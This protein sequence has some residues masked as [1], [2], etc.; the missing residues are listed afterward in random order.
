[1][2]EKTKLFF[3]LTLV[4][5]SG[6]AFDVH[7]MPNTANTIEYKVTQQEITGQVSDKNG[8]I[9]GASV[10]VKGSAIATYTDQQGRFKLSKLNPGAIIV[11]SYVG[12]GSREVKYEG[13]SNLSISLDAT[14]TDLDE[15][16]VVA[17]GTAKKSTFTGSATVVKKEQLEK[18]GGSGFAETL[19]GMSPG[20]N[21][22]NN[23][24]NPG[25]DSR[26]QIRGISSMSGSS[27]PLYVVDG[28]PYDGQLTSIAPSDIESI[29]VLKDAA[30]SSLYGSRAANG[31]IVI[32]TKKGKSAK[33][34][35]NFKS[36]WGTSDNAVGNPTKATP[37]EQLLNT[38]EGMYN[39]QFY[40]YNRTS[41]EAGDW[42]SENV[43]G[44]LLKKAAP[45]FTYRHLK[46]S[47]KI[48]YF[49]MEME[50]RISTPNWKRS[51]MSRTMTIM[52]LYSHAN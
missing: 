30:A 2:S 25:G 43:L 13:Q 5:S 46:I 9:V 33:P 26:I 48:M 34:T 28:M 27:N 45:V 47:M 42:A 21:V 23:E 8:P 6:F 51:G 1:M 44:K 12:Y 17:Y 41:K 35:L 29:T 20:V 38:W 3:A 37:E 50:M 11:V 14:S 40:R 10:S 16:M 24:G 49:M 39:D 15:V 19:Q 18:I 4:A 31:V 7:A 32:T 22:T 52:V 36:T